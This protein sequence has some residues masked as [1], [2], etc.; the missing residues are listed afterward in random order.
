MKLFTSF[1]AFSIL[2]CTVLNAQTYAEGCNG[3]RYAYEVFDNYDM[4]TVKYA[5][6]IPENSDLFV[7]IYQ[8]KNDN[9][10]KRPL[11]I[12]AHGGSFIAGNKS[13]MLPFC[14]YFVKRG[15][16]VASIQYRL[17]AAFP[18][19]SAFTAAAFKAVSDMKGAYRFFK[20]D[21]ANAN[22]YKVDT[23]KIFVG[24]L[25]AGAITALHA[26]YLD[27]NDNLEPNIRTL[28]MANGGFKGNTGDAENKTHIEDDIFATINMSGALISKGL[29]SPDDPILMSYHGD[30]DDV[31][32]VDSNS[33]FGLIYLYGSRTIHKE[34]QEKGIPN[35]L[36]LAPGGLHTDIYTEPKFIPYLTQFLL[37]STN[38]YYP[39]LCGTSASNKSVEKVDI[40]TRMYPNPASNHVNFEFK[41]MIDEVW[42]L[43][44][45]GELVFRK[46]VK[47][48]YLTL[49]ASELASGNYFL[50]PIIGQSGYRSIP[51][52]IVK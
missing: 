7:D 46:T 23:T 36:T 45:M 31:V 21:A 40:V 11:V 52:T 50:V 32:P 12:L 33:V 2:L 22:S 24:G 14:E 35:T 26:T 4:E 10:S 28:V 8:P 29:L 1:F 19:Q 48:D 20:S 51:F 16:V 44:T 41:S 9:V 18:T 17:L 3:F 38:L 6:T 37:N 25:S 42:V 30:M 39:R 47:S 34:A 49:T 27:T 5:T 15:F 43:N 13:D